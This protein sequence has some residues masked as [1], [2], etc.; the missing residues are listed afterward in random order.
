MHDTPTTR[1]AQS[2]QPA[3]ASHG[4]TTSAQRP[5]H[6]RRPAPQHRSRLALAAVLGIAACCA[7]CGGGGDDEPTA[8]P[9]T[10]G[11][12]GV[13]GLSCD[14]TLFVPSAVLAAP[15]AADLTALAGTYRGD[16]GS[17]TMIGF[18]RS[19]SATLVLGA[20]GKVTYNA[21]AQTIQSA[22]I[23]TVSGSTTQLLYLHFTQGH[24]DLWTDG[25]MS[26]VSPADPSLAFTGTKG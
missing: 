17:Y 14:K 9:G 25:R 3:F 2:A 26:G 6:A 11:G 24:V 5:A 7:A 18:V 12:G 23:E 22:C 4:I 15:S 21:T 10:G 19:G 16:E 20:D 8:D 1:Q 13:V